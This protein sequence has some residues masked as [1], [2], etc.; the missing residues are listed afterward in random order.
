MS[1]YV[2]EAMW[3][4][5]ALTNKELRSVW[6]HLLRKYHMRPPLRLLLPYLWWRWKER[7]HA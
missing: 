7:K 1:K 3:Y 5:R 6:F 2:A 4:P